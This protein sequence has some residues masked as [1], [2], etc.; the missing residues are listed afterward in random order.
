MIYPKI[1]QILFDIIF[2][3]CCALHSHLHHKCLVR[4]QRLQLSLRCTLR[5]LLLLRHRP[6]TLEHHPFH[7][8][9]CMQSTWCWSKDL[10]KISYFVTDFPLS[11][12]LYF[13]F[14]IL[15]VFLYCVCVYVFCPF[16]LGNDVSDFL[17]R[18]YSQNGWW[19]DVDI[20][21][22]H[23]FKGSIPRKPLQKVCMNTLV[24]H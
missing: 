17:I 16:V 12:F 8:Y 3:Q 2:R 6:L 19:R 22:F 10:S 9:V 24:L 18:T 1:W 7:R 5:H 11:L 23:I 20:L 15:V 21:N 4:H 13:H 14:R